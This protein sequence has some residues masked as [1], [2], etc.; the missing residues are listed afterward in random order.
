M[1]SSKYS[2]DTDRW[3]NFTIFD[4]MGNI[5]SE[6]G[7][8]FSAKSRGDKRA[9]ESAMIRCL[10][11]F[12]TTVENLIAAKSIKAKEVLRAKEQYL[13]LFNK[14]KIDKNE[15]LSLDKYFLHF[16]LAARLHN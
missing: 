9:A 13:E 7:R 14:K 5:Y 1:S 4:Q 6:V 3:G 8:S 16:A 15:M 12:D 10:D 11:L 2:I